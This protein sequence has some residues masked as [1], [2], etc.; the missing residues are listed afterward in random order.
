MSLMRNGAGSLTMT[1]QRSIHCNCAWDLRSGSHFVKR[2][3]IP[4]E[5]LK[6][7]NVILDDNRD[8]K[9]NVFPYF[10]PYFFP[11]VE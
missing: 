1:T 5:H 6:P 2:M 8:S 7:R 3:N 11:Y 9:G 10:F 4:D